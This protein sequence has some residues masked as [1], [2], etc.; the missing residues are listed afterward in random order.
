MDAVVVRG[1]QI[2]KE[3]AEYHV[4]K[5]VPQRAE[6]ANHTDAAAIEKRGP[7]RATFEVTDVTGGSG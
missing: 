7:E 6:P 4:A 5:F 2:A 1:L 3:G